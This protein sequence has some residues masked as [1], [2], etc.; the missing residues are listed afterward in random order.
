MTRGNLRAVV[1]RRYKGNIAEKVVSKF[2]DLRD[3]QELNEYVDLIE[4][5]LNFDSDRLMRIAFDVYDF[6]QDKLI[7]E[8]DTYTN[9]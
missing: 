9:V 3:P 8:L 1:T 5:L 2:S 4:K 7:C 6:T